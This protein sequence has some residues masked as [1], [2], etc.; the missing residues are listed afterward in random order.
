MKDFF[1]TPEDNARLA[2]II[3]ANGLTHG[4]KIIAIRALADTIFTREY[5]LYL[6]TAN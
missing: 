5:S 1:K 3:E 6:E 4:E 2:K